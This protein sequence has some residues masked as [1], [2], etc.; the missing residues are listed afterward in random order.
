MKHGNFRPVGNEE[1]HDLSIDADGL[2]AT[3]VRSTEDPVL[4]RRLHIELELFELIW[5][6]LGLRDR[7]MMNK[8]IVQTTNEERSIYD[9]TASKLDDDSWTMH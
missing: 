5:V 6:F 9:E 2:E 3:V 8:Y 7:L 1:A 4:C